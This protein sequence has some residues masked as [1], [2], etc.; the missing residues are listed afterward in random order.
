MREGL[1]KYWIAIITFLGSVNLCAQEVSFKGGFVED[2]LV[3]GQDVNFW[4]SAT[5]PPSLEMVFPDSLYSFAPFEISGKTF[6][7]T[8][9]KGN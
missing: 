9:L 1:G 3:I 6:F 8:E 2:S 5:Y 4:V 7:P